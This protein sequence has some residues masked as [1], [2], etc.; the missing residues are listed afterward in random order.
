MKW[1]LALALAFVATAGGFSAAVAQAPPAQCNSFL[2]LKTDAEKKAM[3]VRTAME[4]KAERK[5]ICTLVQH[6]A[7]SE[8]TVIKF[9]EANKTWCGIPEQAIAGAKANH[10]NTLK[11]RTVACTEA[12]AAK[13]RA[14]SLSDA[15]STPSVDTANNTK[16]GRGTLDTLN[17]NPLAK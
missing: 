3:A 8:E 10:E 6:F 7:A 4:H 12:P 14:P 5:D 9:L 17:G 2:G 15:I 1:S 11:F 16:M 13:P